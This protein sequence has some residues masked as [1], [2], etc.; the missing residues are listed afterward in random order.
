MKRLIVTISIAAILLSGCF[1]YV[2]PRHKETEM[3]S[4]APQSTE[5]DFQAEGDKIPYEVAKIAVEGK[6]ERYRA[7]ES[8]TETETERE[9]VTL[10]VTQGVNIRAERSA[11]SERLGGAYFGDSLI[12]YLDTVSDEFVEILY[13]GNVAYAYGACLT[14]NYDTISQMKAEKLA[15]TETETVLSQVAYEDAQSTESEVVIETEEI[16]ETVAETQTETATAVQTATYSAS[17]F[18]QMGVLKWGG[19]KWTYY[20]QR[21]LPGNGLNIPGRHVDENGYVCDENGYIVC[22]ADLSYIARG[23]VIDTPLG[24]QGKIYDT[25]CAYGVI[26]VYTDW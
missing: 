7:Y 22:A 17:Y 6:F 25:G 4:G 2:E 12:G 11:S 8:E 20:S 19:S 18:K 13:E 21:I 5:S 15:K 16:I 23:T 10:Y 24:K 26:D 9:T 14:T 3:P 1:D